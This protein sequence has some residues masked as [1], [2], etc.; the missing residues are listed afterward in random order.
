MAKGPNFSRLDKGDFPKNTQEM[1]DKLGYILN[2]FMEQTSKAFNKNIDFTNLN[3][4]LITFNVVVD[5]AGTPQQKTQLKSTLNT[6][7]AGF[8]V[9]NA[10][11]TTTPANYPTATPFV[12]FTQAQAVISINNISGLKAGDKWSITVLSIGS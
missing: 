5:A 10:K 6:N 9:L 1:I 7:V 4:E 3:Q 11:N 8:S 12:S 2:P